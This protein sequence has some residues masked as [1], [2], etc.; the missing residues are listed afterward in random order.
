[1]TY[2]SASK[3]FKSGGFNVAECAGAFDPETIWAYE[4]GTKANLLDRRLQLNAAAFLYNYDDI[5]INRFI[6]NASSI[7]NAAKADIYG[8]ELEFVAL[9]GDGF[10][11]DGGVTYL[12]HRIR[13]RRELQRSD[14]RW[15]ADQRRRQRSAALA[16]ME[17]VLR[18]AV[19]MGDGYR[20]VF[21]AWR[22]YLF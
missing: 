9:L 16:A 3:G 12:I 17:A 15:T 10:E 4:I 13:W 21:V 1:M 18:S 14:R 6:N 2:V 5:Q 22:R 7:T 19:H 8:A 11:F 20:S